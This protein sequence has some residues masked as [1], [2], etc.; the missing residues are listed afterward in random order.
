MSSAEKYQTTQEESSQL[1]KSPHP[2]SRKPSTLFKIPSTEKYQII[3][4]EEASKLTETVPRSIPISTSPFSISSAEGS[5]T[6]MYRITQEEASKLSESVSQS[7]PI[8]IKSFVMSSAEKYQT[9]QEKTSKLSEYPPQSYTISSSSCTEC[10]ETD[11]ITDKGKWQSS[12]QSS[13]ITQEET[14]KISKSP[15]QLIS[16]SRKS[17][18][19]S[20]AEKYQITPEE[21]TKLSES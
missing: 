3:T 19:M 4:P 14:R 7:I 11:Q 2:S 10:A 5:S 18:A 16:I 1:T 13:L 12:T 17:F 20:S 6:E 15:S 21:A 9:T 8:S